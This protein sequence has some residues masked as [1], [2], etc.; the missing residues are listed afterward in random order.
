VARTLAPLPAG[1]EK[2]RA[3][4]D[5]FDSIARRYDLVNRVITFGMD[6]AWRRRAAGTLGLLDGAV[7]LDI[8]C[9]TGD[10][11]KEAGDRSWRAIGVDFS[12][13]MLG[14][15]RARGFARLVQADALRLPLAD[16]SV[17]GI[18]CGFALRNVA[19]LGALFDEM[20]RVLKRNGRLALLETSAPE[21]KLLKA[22]HSA[23]FNAVVPLIGGL[24]SD[25]EAYAYLPRSAEY[26]PDPLII[27]AMLERAGFDD[28][29]RITQFG[30]VVQ[31]FIGTK[32]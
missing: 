8:A 28:V 3:V 22:G 7:V 2:S 1:D 20:V 30:G 4:R 9:G 21:G 6:R 11:L 32:P 31:T 12:S 25:R 29:H 27:S 23:Y 19:D 16:E 13:E 17:D 15:A 10:F 18:T 24:L 5:M 26:L 14:S